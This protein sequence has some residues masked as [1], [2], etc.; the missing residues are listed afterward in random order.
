MRSLIGIL[1]GGWMT[2]IQEQDGFTAPVMNDKMDE[3]PSMNSTLA[4]TGRWQHLYDQSFDA[5]V[6][7]RL[8]GTIFDANPQA[9]LFFARGTAELAGQNIYSLHHA[10]D[11]R[12]DLDTLAAGKPVSFRSTVL[13]TPSG[14][15]DP[16]H[17]PVDVRVQ[18]VPDED[19]MIYQWIYRDLSNQLAL[20]QLRQDLIV[21]LVHDLQSPLGN[22]ISSLELIKPVI[23]KSRRDPELLLL[24]DLASR[25][26]H[27][28]KRLIDSLL[29][30]RRLEAGKP[31]GKLAPVHLQKLAEN[32]Y[33]I[34]QP[35]LERRGILVRNN[36][37]DT[38]PPVFIDENM[39][40]RVLLNLLDNAL[41][42]SGDGQLITIS[43]EETGDGMLL[44]TVTDEGRGIPEEYRERIFDKYERVQGE[45]S[46][47][48]LGLG[49]A[50]CRLAVEA[51][52]GR[53]WVDEGPAGG[54]R[55]NVTMRVAPQHNTVV[56][57]SLL[58]AESPGE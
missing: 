43:A 23:Q 52:G 8:D 45:T 6:L 15:G 38:L 3:E 40:E 17:C 33:E 18:R 2:N 9:K 14:K 1:R 36:L 58:D 4:Q 39:M 54:A 51:H 29:D 37:P 32:V 48:G 11:R 5:V 20:E 53:I 7:T 13:I 24:L 55:F 27:Q 50:F 28:L 10:D 35:H 49:L 56:A 57:M 26:S 41:K 31:L 21:M 42:Y 19:E 30:I 44:L 16:F 46:S 22:V 47:K 34:E 25:S 12:P